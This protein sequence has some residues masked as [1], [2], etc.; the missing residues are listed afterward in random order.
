MKFKRFFDPTLFCIQTELGKVSF[1]SLFLPILFESATTTVLST[2]N[3]AVISGYSNNAAAAIGACTPI[4][5]MLLLL[6]TVISLGTSVIV[7]NSVG[8]KDLHE[9]RRISFTGI[10]ISTASALLLTPVAFIFA[11]Q[12]MHF[13]NLDGE[14][15]DVAVR[16][17]RIRAIFFLCHAL[18]AYMTALLRCYG[19]ARYLLRWCHKQSAQSRF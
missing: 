10:L 8:A 3:T 14:I 18:S 9:A 11:E 17:F 7:S 2:V 19:Y 12:I 5:S 16:Y 4:I 15:F 6:Q 1:L 13:Q